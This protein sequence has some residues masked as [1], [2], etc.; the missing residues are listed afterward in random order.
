MKSEIIERLGQL[1]LLL[2]ALI[3]EGLAANERAKVRLSVLQAAA[4]RV[5]TPA[6]HFDMTGETRAAGIDPLPLEKLVNGATLANGG[7]ISAPGLAALGA[8]IFDDVA[9]MVGAVKAG[10]PREGEQTNERLAA[11]RAVASLGISDDVPLAEIAALTGFAQD[12]SDSLHR[13]IMD[14]HKAL[15]RLATD[16]AEE[17]LAGAHVHALL[18]D[19]RPAVEAFMRG[20]KATE[21]LKFGHPGLATTATRSGDRLTIQ[22]DIGETDAHVVVIAVERDAVIVTY[23]DVH[24]ARAKFFIGLF[25]EFPVQWSGFERND[26]AGLG[27]DAAFYLVTGRLPLRDVAQRDA[28]LES[29]GASLVFLI[30]WNKAR[31]IFREWV[32]NTDA[33]RL[34]S[35][36][37]HHRIGQ[38]AFLEL[39]GADLVAAAVRHAAP[40][41]IGFGE[42]LDRALGREAAVD[43]LKAVLRVSTEALLQGSSARAARDLIEAS[44]VLHLQRADR[45]LLAT[46]IRQAGLARDIAAGIDRFVGERRQANRPF[47]CAA[48]AERARR[49]EEKAD[50]I[51]IE[52]RSE[53]ARLGT[54]RVLVLLVNAIE[55]A[56]DE[57]E[58]AAFIASLVPPQTPVGLLEP[59]HALCQATLAGTEATACGIAAAAEAPEGRR[60]DTEDALAAISRLIDI[61]HQADAAERAATATILNGDYGFKIALPVLELARALERSTDRMAAFGHLLREH[62]LADLSA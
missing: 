33:I 14:L 8:A 7:R 51:A 5:R 54:D 30:D 18:P 58:Q 48:L 32:P 45:N 49:I 27:D 13:L 39:G 2:P 1:D 53:V 17:V 43:F 35:W 31:K 50:R 61:E 16:H 9:E 37:A 28:F 42:R 15:N 23:T 36:A 12:G 22:N 40:T 29:L 11:I 34:L 25:H 4:N 56:I 46:M 3:A 44:L 10:S 47:D 20:V 52:A 41:R 26:A 19:D 38:R 6:A 60:A 55:D 59:I 57:L 24:H 62:I 21:K